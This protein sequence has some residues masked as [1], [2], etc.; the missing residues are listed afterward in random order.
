MTILREAMHRPPGQHLQHPHRLGSFHL[1]G[2]A[3]FSAIPQGSPSNTAWKPGE[4]LIDG[5]FV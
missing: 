1:P 2:Q 5:Q 3:G 4:K